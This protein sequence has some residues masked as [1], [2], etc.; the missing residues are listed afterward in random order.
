MHHRFL[1]TLNKDEAES[2]QEARE[3]VNDTLVVE[4]FM[5]CGRW[6][7]GPADW[8]VIGGR[9]SGELSRA[10]WAR[11]LTTRMQ[12]MEAEKGVQVWGAWY[13]DPEKQKV[14]KDL[15]RTFQALW[16]AE[17]PVPYLDIPVNRD[18]YREY[19]YEDDAMILTQE[20]YDTLLR[21][22]EGSQ[23]SEH[24]V[25]FNDDPVSLAMIGTKW[26]VVVDYHT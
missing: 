8:F 21:P 1:V 25:D 13:G 19:G 10:S 22:Y 20:L 14:Q 7:Y 18:T 5:T 3:L 9:W 11:E 16:K 4:G 15:E 26:I 17:A 23:D 2:S 24:H 6:A 12:A